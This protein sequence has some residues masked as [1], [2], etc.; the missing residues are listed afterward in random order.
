MTK[1]YGLISVIA[2]A[3]SI[4][5]FTFVAGIA[6]IVT[7]F[8]GFRAISDDS[9]TGESRKSLYFCMIGLALTIIGF[10]LHSYVF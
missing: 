3:I 9:E 4:F 7:A 2:G 8:L 1:R 5:M 6:S 10:L